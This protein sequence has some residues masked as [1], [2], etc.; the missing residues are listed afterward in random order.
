V[1]IA[2]TSGFTVVISANAG[3]T[4][5]GGAATC[6]YYACV[7]WDS[8][9]MKCSTF[10]WGVCPAALDFTPRTGSRD[11]SSGDYSTPTGYGR[12]QYVPNAITVSGG[13][14]VAV[15]ITTRKSK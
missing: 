3:Q 5:T 12:V 14:T 6:Y 2:G 4:I 1:E 13:T 11:A 7:A 10:R 8:T 9:G 15:S